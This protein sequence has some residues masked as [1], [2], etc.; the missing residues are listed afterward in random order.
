MKE[1]RNIIKLLGKGYFEGKCV[2]III[3]KRKEDG[4]K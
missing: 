2:L 3:E 1:K 4:Y